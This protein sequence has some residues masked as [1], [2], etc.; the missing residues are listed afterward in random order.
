MGSLVCLAIVSRVAAGVLEGPSRVALFRGVGRLYGIVGT[1]CLVVAI[2][3]GLAIAWPLSDAS[4]VVV[5]AFIV[6]ALLL[7]AAGLGMA[8][9]RRMTVRR[10][11][12]LAA[13]QDEA[14]AAAAA[15]RRGGEI[16]G[17]LRGSIAVL[18][19]VILVLAAAELSR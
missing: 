16:A 9:A 7:V 5:T 6:C 14:A 13:P 12:A 3:A 11:L 19:L 8:Q 4:G 1:S 17:I 18:T 15:A 10:C 2:A